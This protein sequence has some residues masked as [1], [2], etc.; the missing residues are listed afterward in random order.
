MNE[1]RFTGR[2]EAHGRESRFERRGRRS[3][4]FGVLHVGGMG[5]TGS[6]SGQVIKKYN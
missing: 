5:Y 3:G 2:F 1:N 6:S 4:S